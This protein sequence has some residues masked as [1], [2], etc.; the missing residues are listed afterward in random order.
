MGSDF[1]FLWK[2]LNN[3][4]S[5]LCSL[6]S[7]GR[8]GYVGLFCCCCHAANSAC[9]SGLSKNATNFGNKHRANVSITES[10]ISSE[11]LSESELSI[12]GTPRSKWTHYTGNTLR[13]QPFVKVRFSFRTLKV[14]AHFNEETIG[15]ITD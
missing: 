8:F 5:G 2:T 12:C 11:W 6:M 9:P 1:V 7:R 13:L 14:C 10:G 15:K 3:E 4:E